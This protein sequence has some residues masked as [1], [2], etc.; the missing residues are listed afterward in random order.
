[1]VRFHRLRQDRDAEKRREKDG[2]DPRY[3]ERNGDHHKKR[4]G[5]FTRRGVVETDRNEACHGD[6]RAR[7]HRESGGGVNIGRRFSEIVSDLE[8]RDHHLDGNHR[9]VDE[10][11]ERNDKGAERDTLQRNA[12]VFHVD[13]GDRQHERNGNGNHHASSEAKADEAYDEND[14]NRLEQ[15]RG[16]AGDRFIDHGRLI[17]HTMHIDTNRQIRHHTLHLCIQRLAEM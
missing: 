14:C 3:D 12:C 4:E 5:E 10:K 17:G 7:Q 13:E 15:R 9:I 2:D 16:E 8:P 1:M 11:P 6:Q